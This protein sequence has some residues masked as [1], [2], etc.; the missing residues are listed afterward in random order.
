M[1]MKP[2]Q[3]LAAGLLIAGL[4]AIVRSMRRRHRWES[5]NRQV[6]IALYFEQM[7]IAATRAGRPLYDFLHECRHHGATH[8]AI[9]ED[10]L[11]SLMASGRLI[12]VACDQPHQHLFEGSADL[13]VRLRDEFAARAA[14]CLV[15]ANPEAGTLKLQG[16]LR[17]LRP[18]GL[19]FD[20][21]VFARAR[22][23]G[24]QL[25]ARPVSYPW[26]TAETIERTLSQAAELGARIISFA[27]D[28][29]LGHEMHLN[30]T[31]ASLRRHRLI[32]TYFPDSRHQR[33]DWFIAK[34]AAERTLLALRFTLA[35]LDKGD[36][37]SIAYQAALRAR[38][39][40]IRLI[41]A[42]TY[43]GVHATTP[44]AILHYLDELVH[45]LVHHEGFV[46]DIPQ[47]HHHHD[48]DGHAHEHGEH[49]HGHHHHHHGHEHAHGRELSWPDPLPLERVVPHIERF[50][51]TP[52]ADAGRYTARVTD[53][54]PAAVGLGLLALDRMASLP[55]I[56]GLALAALGLAAGERLAPWLD[57]PRDALERA[58]AP[59]YLPKLLALG[60]L[61]TGGAAGPSSL[62]V[63]PVAGLLAAAAT[64][65]PE[66]YLRIEAIRTYGLDWSLPL[67]VQLAAEPPPLLAGGWR[68]GAALVAL[69]APLWLRGRLP[70]DLIDVLDREH[71][72][73]HTHHLSAAQRALGD[74]R[75]AMSAQ[76]LRKW[77]GLVWLWPVHSALPAQSTMRSLAGLA[78][79]VGAVATAGTL[80][81]PSRP[82]AL[83]LAQVF[84][85]WV[86]HAPFYLAASLAL[87]AGQGPSGK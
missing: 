51:E 31:A 87:A 56:V 11:D 70:A 15:D 78:A 71:P 26:P 82:I 38:E 32:A 67:A 45:A 29:L 17:A 4:P 64:A 63:A 68:W 77:A 62:A 16:D 14:H 37:S 9:L 61:A 25:I 33:G 35:D 3:I 75:M 40:G 7:S 5:R 8:I 57:Q 24:L 50:F 43:I 83:S 48:D 49:E 59:S 18:L 66:Y 69:T 27:G 84:R 54:T 6:Y 86:V 13:I 79:T 22:D 76:P 41:F 52:G 58:Y 46:I 73:G 10:T 36:E 21:E 20:A 30:A 65:N 12:P 72:S 39:G 55:S 44:T 74:A 80:R 1:I 47:H 53:L 2:T 81:N 60:A 34:S 23:A 28:P 42:D 85:S 19:G